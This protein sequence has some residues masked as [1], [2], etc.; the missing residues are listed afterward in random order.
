MKSFKAKLAVALLVGATFFFGSVQKAHAYLP[1]CPE[2]THLV[3]YYDT[4]T[5]GYTGVCMP[6]GDA[7]K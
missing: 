2:G 6:W 4:S 1:V 5:G 7:K 3:I